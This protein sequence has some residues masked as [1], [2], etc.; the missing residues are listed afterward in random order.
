MRHE[1]A[2]GAGFLEPFDHFFEYRSTRQG[3]VGTLEGQL[4][5]GIVDGLDR[6]AEY[7]VTIDY[8]A[9]VGAQHGL[10]FGNDRRTRG[11]AVAQVHECFPAGF[12][13]VVTAL[14]QLDPAIQGFLA[15]AAA[16]DHPD[17]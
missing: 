2:P 8:E 11:F 9:I 16:R 4:T 14:Q 6:L 17:Q 1:H 7:A 5:G 3:E 10:F 12:A 15:T 13:D